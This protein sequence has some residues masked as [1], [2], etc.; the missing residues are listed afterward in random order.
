MIVDSHHHTEGGA[1]LRILRE[2]NCLPDGG[3]AS[4]GSMIGIWQVKMV[5]VPEDLTPEED[6]EWGKLMGG[7]GQIDTHSIRAISIQDWVEQHVRHERV[8]IIGYR[9][10]RLLSCSLNTASSGLFE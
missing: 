4:K 6:A 3:Y 8:R 5:R 9:S 1:A 2:L 7:L 10:G